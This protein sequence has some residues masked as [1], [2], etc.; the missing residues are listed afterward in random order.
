[1]ID[2]DHDGDVNPEYVAWKMLGIFHLIIPILIIIFKQ[3]EDLISSFSK[4]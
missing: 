4:L 1:M 2:D 3:Q